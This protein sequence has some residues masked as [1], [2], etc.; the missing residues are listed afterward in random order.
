MIIRIW[1]G[2][3]PAGKPEDYANHFRESVLP[4][5]RHLPGFVDAMLMRQA[6]AGGFEFVVLTRWTSLDAIKGFAGS[7][8]QRAVVEPGAVA[9]LESF[10]VA[11]EHY[12]LVTDARS[13]FEALSSSA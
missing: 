1:R 6:K 4:E 11:V 8:Y 2:R 13:G 9:A 7:D 5:L 3:A 12:D 10:D